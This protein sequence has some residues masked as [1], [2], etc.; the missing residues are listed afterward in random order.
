M[1]KIVLVSCASKKLSSPSK[2]KDLYISPLFKKQLAYAQTLYPD[3]LFILSAKYGL[4]ETEKIIEPYD[5]TLNFLSIQDVKKWADKVLHQ[6]QQVTHLD[7]DEFVFLAGERYRKFIL[8]KLKH[9]T[10]PLKGL[11]IGKQLQWLKEE[12]KDE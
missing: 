7:S 1:S 12:L 3:K 10:V 11:G 9:F 5:L 8:P 2:A 4:L 6:L